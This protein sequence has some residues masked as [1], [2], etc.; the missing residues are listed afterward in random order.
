M[1]LAEM[2]AWQEVIG[3]HGGPIRP[4]VIDMTADD[5]AEL[6]ADLKAT[7]IVDRANAG[8]SVAAE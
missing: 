6:E 4:P 1:P 5:R 3:M 2:K 8:L 7:G